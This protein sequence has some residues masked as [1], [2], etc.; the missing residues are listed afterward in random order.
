MAEEKNNEELI[1]DLI[2]CSRSLAWGWSEFSLAPDAA[3]VARI[4]STRS[5]QRRMRRRRRT[6][7]LSLMLSQMVLASPRTG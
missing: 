3:E 7:Q 6:L 5:R 2:G 1:E 4:L